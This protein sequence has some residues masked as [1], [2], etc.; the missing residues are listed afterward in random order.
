MDENQIAQRGE[1]AFNAFKQ[2]ANCCQAV[3]LAFE[4]LLKLP[5]DYLMRLGSSFGAGMGGMREVCGSVSGM[6]MVIGLLK[7]DEEKAAHYKLVKQMCEDFKAKNGSIV[8]SQ[9]LKGVSYS[10]EPQDRNAEYYKKR[11]CAELCRDSACIA[12]KYL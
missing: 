11:P 3:L 2:G 7:G 4:D 6:L 10:S 1:K 9:L 8:C 12:A 5:E